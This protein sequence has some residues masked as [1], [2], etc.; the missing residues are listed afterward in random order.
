MVSERQQT[1]ISVFFA[2]I[3]IDDR[4]RTL[5]NTHGF[6]AV[7]EAGSLR[8]HAKVMFVD[9]VRALSQAANFQLLIVSLRD[10]K[11]TN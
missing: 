3:M 5:Q 2:D 10:R 7:Q 4:H 9:L 1:D 6:F 8:S 11:G